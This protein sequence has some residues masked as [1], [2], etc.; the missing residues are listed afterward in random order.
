MT[1]PLARQTEEKKW[2]YQNQLLLKEIIC[3]QPYRNQRNYK[4]NSEQL[5]TNKPHNLEDTR[6]I[7]RKTQINK[8]DS[9]PESLNQLRSFYPKMNDWSKTLPQRKVQAQVA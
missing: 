2:N 4:S 9:K 1:K 3:Y 8:T 5:Y 7:H 6:Q